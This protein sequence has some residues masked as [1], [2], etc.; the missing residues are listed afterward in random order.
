MNDTK[1]ECQVEFDE[2]LESIGID[3]D[4]GLSYP[5]IWQLY[6]K[7]LDQKKR[8]FKLFSKDENFAI[9]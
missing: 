6:E 1:L 4:N 2:Y 3:E 7:F 5:A 8:Q 9:N